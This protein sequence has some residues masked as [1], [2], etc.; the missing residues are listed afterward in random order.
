[1]RTGEVEANLVHLNQNFKLSYIDDLI[2]QK[3]S[4]A[5]RGTVRNHDVEFW[6]NENKRLLALLE[7]ERD[8][9]SL[10]AET[11][12]RQRINGFLVS[13]RLKRD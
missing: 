1:M 8:A 9:S 11:D 7:S 12:V 5:E 6:G 4:G 13:M 10:P 3:L 2:A